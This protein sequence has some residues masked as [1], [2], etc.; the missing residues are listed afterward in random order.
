FSC[1]YV[2]GGGENGLRAMKILIL[3]GTIFLGRHLADSAVARGHQVTLFNRGTHIGS[4]GT[5]I[6]RLRGDR[7]HGLQ[8]L[9]GRRWDAVID[10]CG[11]EPDVVAKSAMFLADSVDHYT[12][13]STIAVYADLGQEDIDETLAVATRGSD[14]VRL[15]RAK[16]GRPDQTESTCDD[17]GPR[18]WPATYGPLKAECE[19]LV[20]ILMAGRSL[21]I[22]PGTIVGP[23]DQ[24]GG[25]T[26]WARRLASD[27]AVLAPDPRNNSVQLIDARDLSTWVMRMV[28]GRQTGIYNATGPRGHLSREEFLECCRQATRGKA[29]VVWVD[30]D[31]LIEH[32][33]A[34][35][36]GIPWWVPAKDSHHAGLFKINCDKAFKAGMQLRP[37]DQTVQDTLAG[38]QSD[39]SGFITTN[40]ESELLKAW[41]EHHPPNSAR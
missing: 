40:E 34:P 30:D 2:R 15:R 21:C 23:Y 12:F 9:Q 39:G 17:Q 22:R 11:Y 20:E 13:I 8:A 16:N 7:T 19:K 10:T 41:L 37:L 6:E 27:S 18:Y 26:Y 4:S 28:E 25:L 29:E 24:S 1:Q 14:D 5:A 31:F 38:V 35:W 3:G 32:G 33:V 36:S